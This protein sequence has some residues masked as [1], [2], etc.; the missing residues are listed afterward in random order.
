LSF[1]GEDRKIVER[2]YKILKREEVRVF[3]D[4][5]EQEKLWGKDLY[6]HLQNIYRDKGRYC[7][8]FVS[9]HYAKKRWT[10]H[11][12]RQAQER[13]FLENQEYILPVRLDQTRLPGLNLT[14]GY[15]DLAQAGI[16]TVAALLLS[17]LG[18]SNLNTQE[19]DRL[20]WDGRFVKYNGAS[21]VS[22]WPRRIRQAQKAFTLRRI[23]TFPRI[24]YGDEPDDWSANDRPCHDCGVIKGQLHVS[25]CDVE[26]C[27]SCKTQLISCDC[28]FL[29]RPSG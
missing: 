8:I 6:Q 2:L 22:Y 5:A 26:H 17:K 4:L 25:G 20:G 23:E 16:P 3:Y 27:P 1:A 11:E 28:E 15:I 19:L 14:T 24:R 29:E 9:Q 12:L 13:A 7:V 18:V 21:M 10:K